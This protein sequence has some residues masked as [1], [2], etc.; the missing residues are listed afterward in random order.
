MGNSGSTTLP[1]LPDRSR[2]N[3]FVVVPAGRIMV[4]PVRTAGVETMATRSLQEQLQII[5][6]GIANQAAEQATIQAEKEAIKRAMI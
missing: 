5:R 3:P 6:S 4:E 2:K 1:N